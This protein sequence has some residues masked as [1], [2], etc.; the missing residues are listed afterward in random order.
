LKEAHAAALL[1]VRLVVVEARA[2][3]R[4]FTLMR[5]SAPTPCKRQPHVHGAGSSSSR[6]CVDCLIYQWPA[7]EGEWRTEPAAAGPFSW[8][9]TWIELKGANPAEMPLSRQPHDAGIQ[10]QDARPQLT[11]HL[12]LARADQIID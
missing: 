8:P 5:T 3:R 9:R 12:A 2:L 4:A 1:G 6:R 10:P 7:S 11:I